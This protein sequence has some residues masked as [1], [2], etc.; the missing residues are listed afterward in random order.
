MGDGMVDGAAPPSFEGLHV[1]LDDVLH[2]VAVFVLGHAE[3]CRREA[4]SPGGRS[5]PL[6][7]ALPFG[8]DLLVRRVATRAI[9]QQLHHHVD[10]TGERHRLPRPPL[11][12]ALAALFEG[13][14]QP[15]ERLLLRAGHGTD[16]KHAA[17]R[18]RH[19]GREAQR[20]RGRGI[21]GLAQIAN[22]SPGLL[23]ARRLLEPTI[24]PL[25]RLGQRGES[26]LRRELENARALAVLDDT[27][28]PSDLD[29]GQKGEQEQPLTLFVHSL[30]LLVEE[31]EGDQGD[32][33]GGVRRGGHWSASL[34]ELSRSL[35]ADA[36]WR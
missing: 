35:T 17:I 9:R 16:A 22:R 28:R 11:I 27:V 20:L 29:R 3:H 24:E 4:L 10:G 30:H 5:R 31:R 26:P 15:V 32:G 34:H 14:P 23:V 2:V 1:A 7:E 13:R 33:F 8:D 25:H 21:A 19:L 12:V 36:A 18:P 6:I